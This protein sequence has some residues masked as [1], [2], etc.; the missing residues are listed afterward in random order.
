MRRE[1]LA[2]AVSTIAISILVAGPGIA[3]DGDDYSGRETTPTRLTPSP[4]T[5]ATGDLAATVT[6]WPSTTLGVRVNAS[7]EINATQANVTAGGQVMVHCSCDHGPYEVPRLCPLG[8]LS[9][10]YP[11][12]LG[13]WVAGGPAT[14]GV[15]RLAFAERIPDPGGESI[16]LDGMVPLQPVASRFYL[17]LRAPD[18][19]P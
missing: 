2:L 17:S 8:T 14:R 10:T 6:I 13:R 15:V 18:Q 19:N 12:S 16:V 11:V 7:L 5:T 9:A 1:I 4:S 3:T